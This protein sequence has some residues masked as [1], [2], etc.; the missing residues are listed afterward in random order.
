MDRKTMIFKR[1][2]EHYNY[3][4][5]QGYEVVCLMLQGSQNYNLDIYEDDYKSDI[6]SKAIIL[7]SLDDIVR[8]KEAISTTLIL[9]NNEHIDVKDVRVMFENFMKENTAY[10]ELLFTDYRIINP[11]YKEICKELFNHNQEI[12]DINR[13]KF[14]KCLSGMSKQKLKALKHPYPTIIDKINKFGYDPK[15][16]HHIIRLNDFTKQFLNNTPFKQC[17]IPQDI[18][19]LLEVKKGY[20][21]L[22]KAEEMAISYDN[23]TYNLTHK[24]LTE[25]DI[26]KEEGINVLN[27]V[28]CRLIEQYLK[29][30]L[31][32][33]D[34]T[35][36]T[37]KYNNVFVISDLH[38][39]HENIIEYENRPF[40]DVEEMNA[41]LIEN[42]NK[43]VSDDDLVYI[44][45]DLSFGNIK[46]TEEI[47]KQLKGDKI[48]IKGNHDIFLDSK[49]FDRNLFIGIYDY[50][51][52]EIFDCKF[53][54]CHYPLTLHNGDIHLYGHIHSNTG[55]HQLKCDLY[56]SYNVGADVNNFTPVNIQNYID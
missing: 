37:K 13:N 33:K 17:L 5:N 27:D 8:N 53:I 7:P 9:E 18:N 49:K 10:I 50:L 45:G 41:K 48:L 25:E 23:E 30:Q 40:K 19:Y 15:Q 2:K 42:W 43:V 35:K 1:L 36:K 4:V 32:P 3:L 21:P 31:Q 29:E 46:A 54:M 12:L 44:L 11:K 55:E 24:N 47:L 20:I 26:V 28:K 51:E 14:L 6:D 22:E 38:F 16:L 56:N 34:E 52:V 39:Y